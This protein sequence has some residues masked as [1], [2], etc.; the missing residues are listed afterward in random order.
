MNF[1]EII[2]IYR[3]VIKY[4]EL[5]IIFNYEN[6]LFKKIDVDTLKYG[7]QK[8]LDTLLVYTINDEYTVLNEC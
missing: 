5:I 4:S 8:G 2:N 6:K 1:F 3:L 7:F